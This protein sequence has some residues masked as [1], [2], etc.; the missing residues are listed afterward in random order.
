MPA[1]KQFDTPL[2]ETIATW[3]R[4]QGH[5]A[6]TEDHDERFSEI[7]FRARGY[8]LAVRVDEQDH[9]FLYIALVMDMPPDMVD[10][11][12]ARRAAA[13]TESR[14]KVIKVELTWES[15]TIV[16][17]A[18]QFVAQPGGMDIFWRA[19]S[20]LIESTRTFRQALDEEIG[21]A[22]ASRFTDELEAQLGVAPDVA[23]MA[24]EDAR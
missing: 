22:A 11:L 24:A 18:E 2:R 7:F 19:V 5:E 21:H 15:R 16:H 3:L 9:A 10:E 8:R 20:T 13:V 23:A 14:T 6:T 12:T 1:M 17:A 4:D